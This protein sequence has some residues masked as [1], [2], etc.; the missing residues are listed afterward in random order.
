MACDTNCGCGQGH[1]DAKPAT[2]IVK[3]NL[4]YQYDVTN[5]QMVFRLQVGERSMVFN[6][7]TEPKDVGTALKLLCLAATMKVDFKAVEAGKADGQ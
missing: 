5:D 1:S 7:T 2:D 3:A 6:Q 4:R